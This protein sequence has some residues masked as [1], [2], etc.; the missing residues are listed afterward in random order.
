LPP[1]SAANAQRELDEDGHSD[2]EQS[3]RKTQS[4]L[5]AE[6]DEQEHDKAGK[7]G[8]PSR[9][10]PIAAVCNPSSAYESGDPQHWR[11][12]QSDRYANKQSA[13]DN[14]RAVDLRID[15]RQNVSDRRPRARGENKQARVGQ[16]IGAVQGPRLRG[17]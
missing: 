9:A 16:A 1:P 15:A 8:A 5:C 2:D 3:H 4:G 13:R 6:D 11:D 10:H 17:A 14:D 7:R 12:R